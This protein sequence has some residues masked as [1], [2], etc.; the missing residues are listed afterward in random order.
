MLCSVKYLILTSSIVVFSCGYS[1]KE[2]FLFE[3]NENWGE[4]HAGDTISKHYNLKAY[5]RGSDVIYYTTNFYPNGV[6]KCKTVH[7]NDRLDKVYF[8]NDTGGH[9]LDFGEIENG[10][11]HVN[12]YD[13]KGTLTHSGNYID[14]NK[15][16]WWMIYHFSGYV[17]DS[18]LYKDGFDIS[19]ADN[20]QLNKIFGVSGDVRDNV[21][22]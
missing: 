11:G 7:I 20:P 13:F 4:W 2:V 9:S 12:I 10:N 1:N 17:M 14:G 19:T 18:I 22:H 16:G 3:Q 8:V 5:K 21:Y 15:E 6:E